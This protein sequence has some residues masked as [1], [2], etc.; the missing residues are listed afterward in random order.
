MALKNLQLLEP[1]NPDMVYHHRPVP[2]KAPPT[3]ISRSISRS[4]ESLVGST[5]TGLSLRG[6]K[7]RSTEQPGAGLVKGTSTIGLP[8]LG[9]SYNG[10]DDDSFKSRSRNGRLDLFIFLVNESHRSP[11]KFLKMCKGW[12]QSVWRVKRNVLRVRR[13]VTAKTTFN[14]LAL[15]IGRID[16]S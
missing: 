14:P 2:M 13:K 7:A 9:K 8:A 3:A 4:A 6:R 5:R 1:L 10:R 15:M 12:L 11:L 16:I